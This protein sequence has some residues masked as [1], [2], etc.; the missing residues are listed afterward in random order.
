LGRFPNIPLVKSQGDALAFR[1]VAFH[2]VKGFPQHPLNV[3]GRA[4]DDSENLAWVIVG[5][6]ALIVVRSNQVKMSASDA[7]DDSVPIAPTATVNTDGNQTSVRNDFSASP[8][9]TESP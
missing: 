8:S 6:V 5:V 7:S 4:S 9:Q 1:L 3:H 2:D